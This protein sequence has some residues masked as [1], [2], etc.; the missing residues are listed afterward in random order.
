MS[1][2]LLCQQHKSNGAMGPF[3]NVI[4]VAVPTAQKQLYV[5]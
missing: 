5:D 1:S 2:V 4:S 3:R